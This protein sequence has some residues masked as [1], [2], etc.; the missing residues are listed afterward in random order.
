[1]QHKL[2]NTTT[3]YNFATIFKTKYFGLGHKYLFLSLSDVPKY[4]PK[5]EYF[6]IVQSTCG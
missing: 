1:M 2:C 6:W 4:V 5:L 3:N